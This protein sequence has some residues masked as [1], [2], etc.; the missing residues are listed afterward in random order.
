[1]ETLLRRYYE[2]PEGT[3]AFAAGA[4]LKPVERVLVERLRGEAAGGGLLGDLLGDLLDIGVGAGRTAAALSAL[5]RRY[6]GVDYS[7]GM[8]GRCRSRFPRLALVC[9]D[10]RELALR[11]A[12]FDAAFC[13]DVLGDAGHE[14][15]LRILAELHRVLRPGGALVMRANN[16]DAAW[17]PPWHP[18]GLTAPG[19]YLRGVW[20]HWR[21]RGLWSSGPGW[22]VAGDPWFGYA[23]P[24]YYVRREEQERQLAAA[25]FESVEVWRPAG[26]PLAAGEPC[27]DP[28][29]FYLARTR[30]LNAA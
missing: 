28:F 25:G 4:E 5:G 3:A 18:A 10:A 21:S 15:R 2:S 24:S 8:L 16:L 19:R 20:H 17:R 12:R 1:M 30:T 23:L 14:G 6:L 29:L 7:L 11:S 22:R 13:W 9:C 26:T 27:G